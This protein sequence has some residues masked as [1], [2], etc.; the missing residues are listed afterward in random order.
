M[1]PPPFVDDAFGDK[2][3]VKVDF[4][5]WPSHSLDTQIASLDVFFILSAMVLG[6]ALPLGLGEIQA[7]YDYLLDSRHGFGNPMKYAKGRQSNKCV[8]C[9]NYQN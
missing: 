5:L 6:S 1:V 8:T 7:L 2:A 3:G 9:S 4:W